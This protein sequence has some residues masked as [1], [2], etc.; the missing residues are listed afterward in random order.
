LEFLEKQLR[1]NI[2]CRGWL[3]TAYYYLGSDYRSGSGMAYTLSYMSQMG[4]WSVL[5]Y[6]L[7][8]A[9]DPFKYLRLGYASYLS[10][11]ALMNTGTSQSNYGYWYPGKE[12]DG[13]AG[14]GF[15]PI[16]FATSWLGKSHARGCWYYSAEEDVGY[17]GAIRTSAAIIADD[18][19]F[20]LFAYGGILTGKKDGIEVIPKDGLRNN[21]HIIKE[22]KRFSLLL[23]RDGFAEDQS[24]AVKDSLEEIAFVLENRAGSE[25]KTKLTVS[26][27]PAGSFAVKINGRQAAR[28]KV[29]SSGQI[30]FNIPVSKAVK[31]CKVTI[32]KL[33]DNK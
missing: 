3:E 4:G 30:V 28:Q 9:K 8:Y 29:D 1:L 24:I 11:W 5:D 18:P 17:N 21:L 14:G 10:S 27:L 12:N 31:T 19:L 7:Y 16:S 26:G 20:G 22:N 25:H 6:A 23:E 33:L 13:A 2:A 32:V 15:E